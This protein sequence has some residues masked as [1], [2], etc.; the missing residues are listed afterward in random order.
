MKHRVVRNILGRDSEHRVSLLRNLATSLIT[1][2]KIETTLAKAKFVKP[3]V[4]KLITKAKAGSTFNNVKYLKTKLTTDEAIR[5][6][7]EKVAPSF[8]ERNGGYTRIV[9]TRLRVGDNSIMS[10][11]ELVSDVKEVKKA[12]GS[13]KTADSADTTV[14]KTENV[15]AKKSVRA[16]KVTK[17]AGPKTAKAPKAEKQVEEV[18]G[19]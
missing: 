1:H 13:K 10:R 8:A 18:E 11:I 14:V 15:A 4:E 17:A 9:R 5:L 2:G 12:R 7:L 16:A 3:Y 6:I 19:K